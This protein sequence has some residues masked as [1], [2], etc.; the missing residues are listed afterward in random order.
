MTRYYFVEPL[1]TL[2]LRGNLAFGAGGEHGRAQLPPWPS[3]FAG[4]FR[5]AMLATNPDA[6][7]AFGR[8][9][10]PQ[11]AIG[12]SLGDVDNPGAFRLSWLSLARINDNQPEGV[13][14]L[15]G[16][17]IATRAED[18]LRFTPLQPAALPNG[19][20][21]SQTRLPLTP[22]LKTDRQVKPEAARLDQPALQSHLSGQPVGESEALELYKSETRLGIA[23]DSSSRTAAEGQ[24]YTTEAITFHPDCGF[25]VGIQGAGDALPDTGLLRLGGD[26]RGASYRRVIY[27]PP[28]ADLTAIAKDR[29]FRLI[30]ATPGIFPAGWLPPGIKKDA[31][32]Y[33]LQTPDFSARLAAASV[34]R[35]ETVSGWDLAHKRPKTARKTAPTGSVYWFDHFSGDPD[36]LAAWVEQGLWGETP[37]RFRQAEG[38]NRAWL[39]NWQPNP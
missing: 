15:P 21:G 2:M 24:L 9:E 17:L 32:S 10:K 39:A 36:T 22:L 12:D 11:G 28:L 4:A 6:M 30:L 34:S 33:R 38:F 16:D 26:G 25:L 18:Q 19:S 5:S 13:F 27:Q 23:L 8:G 14:N 31:D 1:D 20:G 35:N 29:A 3:A 37:D 7:Q